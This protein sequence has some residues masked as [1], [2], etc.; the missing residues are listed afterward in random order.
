[1]LHFA[2]LFFLQTPLL[3][4]T[5]MPD[6]NEKVMRMIQL[7]PCAGLLLVPAPSLSSFV[8]LRIECDL[9]HPIMSMCL[10]LAFVLFF[11]KIVFDKTFRFRRSMSVI[12]LIEAT[13]ARDGHVSLVN[14]SV[15]V[16][17]CKQILE[18]LNQS[19]QLVSLLLHTNS[20]GDDGAKIIGG[21]LKTNLC[22]TSL[23]LEW[24]NIGDE[25][26]MCIGEALKTNSFLTSLNL[27]DNNVG[28]TG[29][30]SIGEALKTNS[31]LSSLNLG[32]N[33]IRD[34]GAK[35]IGGALKTNSCLTSLNLEWN[36]IGDEGV[37]CIGE[38]LES[39]SCLTSLNLKCN[40]IGYEGARSIG[41]ALKTNSCLTSLNLEYNKI[42][43][44]GAKCIGE[45]LKTNSCLTSLLLKCNK[46]GDK[47]AKC[48]E[49][50]L[51]VNASLTILDLDETVVYMESL[52]V[53]NRLARDAVKRAVWCLIG[54][55]LH[56][57][58]ECG[59]LGYVPKE[60]VLFIAQT[61]WATRGQ[62][63]WLTCIEGGC[64][65]S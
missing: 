45:T 32:Y 35:C 11:F 62:L 39:N 16:F 8:S 6:E 25:G 12:G 48:I 23:D 29:A 34:E 65:G 56:R 60:L 18:A 57:R 2:F 38:A 58:G 51:K 14:V 33:R 55:R 53:R 59:L 22:L 47:G 9:A 37:L 40:K 46:I 64:I 1:V 3:E 21:A 13:K 42:G 26:A 4:R 52:L 61:L 5:L 31:C 7:S 19:Q 43:D 50:A 54:I 27:R 24:N 30:K 10:L 63:V 49:E 17:D 44:E 41:E 28:A 20:I 36:N 15:N